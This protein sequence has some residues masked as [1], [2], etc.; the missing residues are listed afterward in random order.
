MTFAE[1][2]KL[3]EIGDYAFETT[4]ITEIELPSSLRKIGRNA[5]YSCYFLNTVH[6]PEG[7]TELSAYIFYA[8]GN[9]K[10]IN[11]PSTL[12][13]I[14][15]YAFAS[16]GVEVLEFPAGLETIGDYAFS[17][18]PIRTFTAPA[19]LVTIGRGHFCGLRHYAGA[20]ERW[21]ED[22]RAAAFSQT[23]LTSLTLP[24]SVTEVGDF[25][26]Q[27]CPVLKEVTIGAGVTS[28]YAPFVSTPNLEHLFRCRWKY[29][30]PG[31]GQYPV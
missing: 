31:G 1:G 14:G 18:A 4:V 29:Q 30:L 26:L 11:L 15:D 6:L 28:L 20:P 22:H 7:L 17:G 12:K 27:S 5:F 3:Y 10:N 25:V 16:C 19:G 21:I 2:G 23:Y 8:C 13:T 9:L 24:D